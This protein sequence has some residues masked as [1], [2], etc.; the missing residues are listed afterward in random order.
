V[1]KKI[2]DEMPYLLEQIFN[3][4]ETGLFYHKMPSR[5]Y[6][7]KEEKTKPRHKASK[8]RVTLLLGGNA[9]GT[10]KVKPLLVHTSAN[11]RA[12]KGITKVTL[13]V[14]LRSNKKAW[15]TNL[16][17]EDWFVNCFLPEVEIYC[18]HNNLPFKILLNLDNPPNHSTHIDDN[19]PNIKVVYL[20]PPPPT[21]LKALCRLYSSG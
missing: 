14:H 21:H 2:I 11:P 8:K 6:I 18:Q 16:I 20:P 10:Y 17:F 3:V 13:P 1:A 5:T 4:D 12:L 7:S 9:S 19:S 15:I